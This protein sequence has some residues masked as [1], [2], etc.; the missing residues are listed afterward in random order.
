MSIFQIAVVA[1]FC[2]AAAAG[3]VAFATFKGF[4]TQELP[5]VTL[6][7]SIPQ[8]TMS[9]LLQSDAVNG[10]KLK[11]RYVEKSEDAIDRDL[12]EAIATGNTPDLVLLSQEA[13][14][15]HRNKLI[16]VPFTTYSERTFKDTYIQAGDT[17]LTTNGVLGFPFLVDPMVMYYNRTLFDNAGI[18]K[19]PQIWDDFY[20]LAPKF[21]V[22][23]AA[24]NLTRTIGA[25]GLSTNIQNFK[26]TISLLML[27]QGNQMV[28]PEVTLGFI[29]KFGQGAGDGKSSPAD[30]TVRFLTE[31]SN[32]VKP[33]YSWNRSFTNDK[34]SFLS[35]VLGTYFGY[36]SELT[37]IRRKNP[38]LNYDLTLVPQVRGAT[39]KT[40]FGK[41]YALTIPKAST[42][43]QAAF[44]SALILTGAPVLTE[45]QKLTFLPPVRRDML[46]AGA[47]GNAVYEIF[48][49]SALTTKTWLDPD[50]VATKQIFGE[51]IDNV[52][53]G[54]SLISEAVTLADGKLTNILTTIKK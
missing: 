8:A 24:G 30:T 31:F 17:F 12:S 54:K 16:E 14:L 26:N 13:L 2:F 20:T 4:T 33:V 6:W 42:R 29:S 38:N 1:F 48:Y 51:M 45:V 39:V 19:P 49:Q 22:R 25:F 21:N 5:E 50:R 40:T 7:G 52:A 3:L 15:K 36:A 47:G 27:Q 53:S 10:P 18:A 46:N 28:V 9:S 41:L 23:D 11:I 34:Q 44:Q 32:P 35:G 37:D 43:V